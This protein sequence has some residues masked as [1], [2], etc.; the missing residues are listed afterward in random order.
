VQQLVADGDLAKNLAAVPTCTALDVL[1]GDHR[2]EDFLVQ[3]VGP[4]HQRSAA[5]AG[6]VRTL[7]FLPV[8]CGLG[9]GVQGL[10]FEMIDA[11]KPGEVLVFD[12]ARGLGGA[13]LGDMLA[14]RAARCSAAGLV[15]DGAVRD[16]AGLLDSGLPVFAGSRRPMSMR[17]SLAAFEAD[18]PIQCGGVL[19]MPGDLVLADQDAVLVMPTHVAALVVHRAGI[20]LQKETFCRSLLDQGAPLCE[21][22]P[23]KPWAEPLFQRYLSSGE[24]PVYSRTASVKASSTDRE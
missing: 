11:V 18:K 21:A 4:I 10:N 8:R 16:L 9:A 24:L 12:T 14:L 6:P 23:L 22:Y 7:R 19:V 1:M 13:V 5:I 17:G 20:A 2:V 15:T 3:G